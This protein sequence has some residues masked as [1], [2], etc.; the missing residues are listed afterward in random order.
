MSH[1]LLDSWQLGRGGPQPRGGTDPSWA[2][3][4][5]AVALFVLQYASSGAL[6]APLL[7]V[8][9]PGGMPALDAFLLATAAALWAAFD[10][11]PQA[12]LRRGQ[13]NCCT[14]T[15][16]LG[17]RHAAAPPLLLPA[18]GLF[19]AALTTAAGPA[20]EITLINAL[21]LYS[22]THPAVCGVP[23]WIPWVYA[24]GAPA[25]GNLGRKVSSALLRRPA[26]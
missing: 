9:L 6:E 1:P 7:G 15:A 25:V 23:T 14:A 13:R 21:H 4:L 16:A 24:A 26:R 11:T 18:Q 12:C 17:L 3:V 19:M 20:V 10:G 2:F 5:V 8:T 22:Y